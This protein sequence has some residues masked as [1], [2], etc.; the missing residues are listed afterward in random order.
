VYYWNELVPP[1]SFRLATAAAAEDTLIDLNSAGDAQAGS[2]IQIESEVL[3][4]EAVLNGGTQYQVKRAMHTTSASSHA[5]ESAVYHL[6]QTVAVVPFARDFF[7]SPACGDWGYPMFLPNVKVASAELFVTN[8]VG[9]GATGAISLT[10]TVDCGLRT[11][12]GGQYSLQV[13]G[14]LAI[15]T[16][17]APDL[18]VEGPHAVRD[19]FAIVKQAPVGGS[20]Q[21]QVN[22]NGS[23]YSTLTIPDGG[24]IS[25]VVNGFG[26]PFLDA[27]YR[28]S[29][30][31]ISCGVDNPGS[32]LTVVI[33]L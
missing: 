13:D 21:I 28:I 33:R 17:A 25:N 5:V 1:T 19:L 9:P 22:Y 26:L 29:M 3:Q 31:I 12:A 10:Q 14:F 27:G 20:V 30:D 6:R 7:G 16:G 8:S 4:V 23:T 18:V 32:D 2:M 11:L 24:T 15:Q